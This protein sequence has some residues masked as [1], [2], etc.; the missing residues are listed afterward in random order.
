MVTDV[1]KYLD[2]D[3]WHPD[4][5]SHDFGS[6]KNDLI[7]CRNGELLTKQPMRKFWDGFESY[8]VRMKDKDSQFLLLKLK[9]WPPDEEFSE[10]LPS[11]YRDLMQSLPLPEYT[12]RNGV[13]NLASRLPDCFVRPDLGPKMYSAYGTAKTPE[14]G[15]TNLHLDISDAVNV[16]TFVGIPKDISSKMEVSCVCMRVVRNSLRERSVKRQKILICTV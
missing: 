6:D 12:K 9:D 3:L 15:T 16:M 14:R 2:H 5:F 13:L 7:N 4:S 11:R 1:H 10:M 8:S